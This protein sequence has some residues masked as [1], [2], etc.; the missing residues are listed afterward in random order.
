MLNVKVK[1][2]NA[3]SC[4]LL[5]DERGA[6]LVRRELDAEEIRAVVVVLPTRR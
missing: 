2:F 1:D 3:N 6:E 4:K 5:I